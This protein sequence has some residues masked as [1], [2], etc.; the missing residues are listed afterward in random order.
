MDNNFGKKTGCEK[1]K[2]TQ[3]LR[4]LITQK[5]SDANLH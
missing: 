5:I 3:T 2:K 1:Q 4:I